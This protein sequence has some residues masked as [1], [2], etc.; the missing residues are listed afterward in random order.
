MS[1]LLRS[2]ANVCIPPRNFGAL[3]ERTKQMMFLGLRKSF[4]RESKCF[5]SER[6]ILI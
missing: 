2:R 1:M 3:C 4:K 5:V 6:K